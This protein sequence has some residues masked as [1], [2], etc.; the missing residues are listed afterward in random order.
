MAPML[1]V[2]SMATPASGHVR[3]E[4]GD[5]I[6]GRNTKRAQRLCG[7]AIRDRTTRHDVIFRRTALSPQNTMPV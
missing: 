6:A 2:A 7:A 5:A 3:H 4:A 1:V